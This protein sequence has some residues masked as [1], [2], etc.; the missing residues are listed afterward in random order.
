M[1][2]VSGVIS[3]SCC[4]TLTPVVH[5]SFVFQGNPCPSVLWQ[6]K[7]FLNRHQAVVYAARCITHFLFLKM[8]LNARHTHAKAM[9]AAAKMQKMTVTGRTTGIT[10][11]QGTPSYGLRPP[12]WW[13]WWEIGRSKREH[14][15]TR[16]HQ[17]NRFA[18]HFS[19]HN[20]NT[21]YFLNPLIY[22]YHLTFSL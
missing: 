11:S 22:K 14:T 9:P 8:K 7:H 12:R 3:G 4:K 15:H 2:K 5:N 19:R 20:S 18:S 10:I 21:L 17:T 1:H 13:R 6:T 16:T